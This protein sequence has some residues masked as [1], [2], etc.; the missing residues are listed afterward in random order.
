MKNNI[1]PFSLPIYFKIIKEENYLKIKEDVNN[2]ISTEKE[3]FE[4]PKGWQCDTLSTINVPAQKNINS[5]TL[6]NTIQKSVE[7]YYNSWNYENSLNLFLER[8]WVNVASPKAYQETHSHYKALFSGVLYIDVDKD[9][10]DICF[11]NPLGTESILMEN[12]KT[13][14]HDYRITPQ[15]G[16]LLIFP[17]WLDHSVF[18]NNTSKNRIS[19]SFNIN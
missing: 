12:P 7:E 1:Y 9:S 11:L 15:N 10:G 13:L 3:L 4:I 16:L 6:N 17:G 18:P 14:R 8:V 19:I 2:F 5:I